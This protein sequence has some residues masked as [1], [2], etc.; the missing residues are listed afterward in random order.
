MAPPVSTTTSS[1]P[2]RAASAWIMRSIAPGVGRIGA[3]THAMSRA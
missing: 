2:V 1:R 3:S